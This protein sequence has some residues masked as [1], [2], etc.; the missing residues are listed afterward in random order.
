MDSIQQFLEKGIRKLQKADE[1]FAKNPKD[2]AGYINNVRRT[3]N[4]LELNI[5]AECLESR[6]KYIRESSER[7]KKWHV[8]RKD[9]KQLIT[10]LGTVV[11]QKTLYRNKETGKSEY[12]LDK[13]LGFGEHER[14]TEDALER[15]LG[16]AVDTSYRR[17]GEET[18]M[19]EEKVSKTAVMDVIHTLKFPPEKAPKEKRKV[20]YLYVDADEDHVHLQEKGPRLVTEDAGTQIAKLVY[21]YEGIEPEAP[22]SKRYRL[23]HPHYISGVYEGAENKKLWQEVWQYIEDNYDTDSL[24]KIYLNSD[25]GSWIKAAKGALPNPVMVLDEFHIDEYLTKMTAFLMDSAGD[26]RNE[27]RKLIQK[28]TKKEFGEYCDKLRGAA[29]DNATVDRINTC[30]AYLTSNWT[31]A[32]TRLV[33]DTGVKGCSAEAHVEHVLSVRMSSDPMG[34]SKTGVD[35]MSRLRAYKWN[36]GNMLSLARYQRQEEA[37]PKAAGSEGQELS[38]RKILSSERVGANYEYRYVDRMQATV[39]PQTMSKFYFREHIWL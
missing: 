11:F 1:E 37:L 27:L 23:I 18:C 14:I 7:K 21:I 15:M 6:D 33:K 32:K 3:T 16:E 39:S 28:G 12:L 19:N 13:V 29:G 35:R 17:G 22:Q 8:V 26:A 36:G 31:S 4:E 30:E 5:I 38:L 24:E 9:T 25:G 10:S 2:F 34:W 20:E